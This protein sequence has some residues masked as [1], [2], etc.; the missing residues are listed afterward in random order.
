MKLPSTFFAPALDLPLKNSKTL[1]TMSLSKMGSCAA[2]LMLKILNTVPSDHEGSPRALKFRIFHSRALLRF[3]YM[4]ALPRS[5]PA[6]ARALMSARAAR[7]KQFI[8]ARC[9]RSFPEPLLLFMIHRSG[10][11]LFP[12]DCWPL[13]WRHARLEVNRS[14]TDVQLQ[15]AYRKKALVL[16]LHRRDAGKENGQGN[17]N[18]FRE[19]G[20]VPPPSSPPP[21]QWSLPAGACV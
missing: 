6:H 14:C 12:I 4:A 3:F 9:A 13:A 20:Q 19:L 16:H 7:S 8:V 18:A 5:A 10:S 11:I 1:D 17:S 21:S 15:Q 2:S